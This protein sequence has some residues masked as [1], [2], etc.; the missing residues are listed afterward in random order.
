MSVGSATTRGKVFA[1]ALF[2]LAFLLVALTTGRLHIRGD[3]NQMCA[4]ASSISDHGWI[5]L[6][7]IHRDLHVAPDGRRYTKYP[8]GNILQ[9]GAGLALKSLGG[10]LDGPNTA[11]QW[12]LSGVFPALWTAFLALGFFLLARELGFSRTVAAFGALFVVFASPIWAY[13][14]EMYS[15]NTQAMAITWT[16]WAYVKA[17]RLGT[18]RHYLLGGIFVGLAIHCKTPLA[19]MGLATMIY[20]IAAR[21]ERRHLIRFFLYGAIGFAPFLAAFL[22]YN[23]MRYGELFE[24]GYTSGRDGTLGFA[25]P[26]YSGLHGLLFSPGKSIFVY[27]PLLLLMPFGL[28]PMWRRHRH[29]LIYAAIPTV[30]IFL[31]MAKW[32]SGLGDWGWGPRLV[33]PLYPLLFLPILYV[34]ERDGKGWRVAV[35]TLATLGVAVNFLGIIIDHAHYID[36]AGVTHAGMRLHVLPNFIRDDLVVLHYVPEFSPPV[37]HGWLLERFLSEEPWSSASWY[38]WKSI[39]IA[40]WTPTR[41]PTP[42]YLNHWSDGS[43]LAWTILAIGYSLVAIFAATLAWIASGDRAR[44]ARP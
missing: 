30:A 35:V 44:I 33:V 16:L 13:G 19:I 22:G 14:R 34:L 17:T 24:V 4:A 40:G 1:F 18:R 21:P 39:G 15:E 43:T 27:A 10:W 12:L 36:V 6:P 38:P 32:W 7:A 37:G 26:L 28:A 8:L 41:D 29:V 9:C 2:A 11:T 25:T 20:V 5:D 3:A 23:W 42:R 31:M